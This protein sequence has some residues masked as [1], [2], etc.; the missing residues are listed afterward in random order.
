MEGHHASSSV[1]K[2]PHPPLLTFHVVPV[3]C[4]CDQARL[5]SHV[6][7]G[8]FTFTTNDSHSYQQML[9]TTLILRP[10]YTLQCIVGAIWHIVCRKTQPNKKIKKSRITRTTTT[11]IIAYNNSNDKTEK[12]KLLRGK[13]AVVWLN[14]KKQPNNN[15]KTTTTSTITRKT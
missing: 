14:K 7:K 6:I 11:I 3:A 13:N 1:E 10:V 8:V 9:Q 5:G 12:H 15:P 2:V 4:C